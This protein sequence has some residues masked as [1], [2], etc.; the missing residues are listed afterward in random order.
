MAS[1]VTFLQQSSA[2]STPAAGEVALYNDNSAVPLLQRVDPAGNVIS[3]LDNFNHLRTQAAIASVASAY[4]ADTYLAGSGI[5]IPAGLIRAKTIYHV[6][7]DMT[8][9]AAGTAAPTINI[10]IGTGVVGDTSRCLFTFGAG[11]AAADA[12]MFE[13]WA[14]L[15]SIG[16]GTSAVLQGIVECRHNLAATGLISTGASGSGRILTT[17]GGF[18]STTIA[19]SVIGISFNG[20][21]SFSGTNTL[22]QAR[23]YNAV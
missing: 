8:K 22:V 16:S 5:I 14:T 13:L 9:T 19:G 2:P 10:R 3:Q 11:T 6:I 18:D 23:L 1:K 4:A 12:G 20:G 7:F 17:G 15:I 21:A